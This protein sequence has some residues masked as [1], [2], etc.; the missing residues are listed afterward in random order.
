MYTIV[1]RGVIGRGG[2]HTILM[3]EL[4]LEPC[5]FCSLGSNTVPPAT[6]SVCF[7]FPH[8]GGWCGV[9]LCWRKSSVA[10]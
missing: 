2:G 8:I 3:A 1:I 7:L 5:A 9:E 10:F 6:N 4:G